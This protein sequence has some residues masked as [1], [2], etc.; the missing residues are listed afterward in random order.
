MKVKDIWELFP[1][2][3]TVKIIDSDYRVLFWGTRDTL[4]STST[5]FEADIDTLYSGEIYSGCPEGN[6]TIKVKFS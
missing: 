6:V 2:N 4:L 3:Q 1:K 5:Y